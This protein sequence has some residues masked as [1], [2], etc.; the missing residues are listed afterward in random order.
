MKMKA[1]AVAMA[2]FAAAPAGAAILD[3][4]SGNGEL[5]LSVNDPVALKSY[6][7]DLGITMSA[8]QPGSVGA[9]TGFV[10]GPDANM[11]TFLAGVSDPTQL[12]WDVI[13]LDSTGS[14]AGNQN[15]FTT[16]L[17]P[18][19]DLQTLFNGQLTSFSAVNNYISA[20]N[21]YNIPVN[22]SASNTAA[23]VSYLVSS[24]NGA[25]YFDGGFKSIDWSTN[26]N[27]D[28]TA[29]LGQSLSFFKLSNSTNSSVDP[30]SV[31]EFTGASFLLSSNGTLSYGVSA[32]PV[33]AAVW[34]FGSGLVGMI[35]VARRK[36]V[37]A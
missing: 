16:T 27:F 37:S 11:T 31:T 26:A 24:A 15:Y 30:I 35:G 32:V 23:N 12:Q 2:I 14:A 19:S 36:T 21:T 7:L 6:A 9:T 33:P 17:S 25:A 1:I 34:L 5:V 28:S 20:L 13:A 18:I 4:T 29:G 8:F 3:G 10:K 22:G